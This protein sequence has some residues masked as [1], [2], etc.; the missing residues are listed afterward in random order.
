MIGSG[1]A[2]LVTTSSPGDCNVPSRMI[3]SS[4]VVERADRNLSCRP[5]KNESG[6]R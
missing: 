2:G 5:L 6:K 3:F 1:S 4:F